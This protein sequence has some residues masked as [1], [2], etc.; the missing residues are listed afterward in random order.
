MRTTLTT[1]RVE[2]HC[3]YAVNAKAES[4][5]S[6]AP[7]ILDPTSRKVSGRHPSNV[8]KARRECEVQYCVLLYLWHLGRASFGLE[9]ELSHV[10]PFAPAGAQS[11][12]PPAGPR[13]QGKVCISL[14]GS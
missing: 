14:S 2:N 6:Q 10:L 3:T 5:I 13:L 8:P 7:P 9:H 12:P 11:A 1:T 4:R